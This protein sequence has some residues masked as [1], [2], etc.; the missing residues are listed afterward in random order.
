MCGPELG[1]AVGEVREHVTAHRSRAFSPRQ[2]KQRIQVAGAQIVIDGPPV[3][4][5]YQAQFPELVALIKVGNP[6]NR[7]LKHHLCQRIDHP[8]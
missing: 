7:D 1:S 4:R 5:V 3:I 8:K 6:G 2:R